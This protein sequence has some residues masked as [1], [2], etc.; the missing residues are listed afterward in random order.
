VGNTLFWKQEINFSV[1]ISGRPTQ[2]QG[3]SLRKSWPFVRRI[4]GA[5]GV[6]GAF[7]GIRLGTKAPV[8]AVRSEPDW[9]GARLGADWKLQAGAL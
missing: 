8:P 5:N 3:F 4:T 6:L 9:Y 2:C 1:D 7:Q